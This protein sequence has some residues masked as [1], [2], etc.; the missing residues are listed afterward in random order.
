MKAIIIPTPGEIT[1]RNVSSPSRGENDV[2]VKVR[3]MGICGSDINA[4]RGT[5]PLV[6]YPRIIGHEIAGEVAEIPAGENFLAV[7]DRVVIE[8]YVYCGTCYP[9]MTQRTNCCENLRVRGVHIDGGMSEYCAHPRHLVHKVA[10][11]VSW[12]L[13]AMVEPLTISVHA[14]RR[15]RLEAGEHLVVTGA[16]PI[17]ILAALFAKILGAVPIVLDPLESRLE[18]ARSLGIENT[19]NL[20]KENAVERI[21]DLTHGRMAEALVEASGNESAVRSSIDYVSYASRISLVGWPKKEVS[22]PTAL[23]T[24]KEIDVMGSRNSFHAF[25][26]SISLISENKINI[27]PLISEVVPFEDIPR[28]LKEVASHPESFMKIV[29]VM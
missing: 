15:S 11:K 19:V 25:P 12:E 9:C 10:D 6:T 13:L 27:R 29:G 21:R 4:Y 20:N 1:L 7:G 3:S 23:F 22:L 5:N 16:G 18:F 28:I 17:G 8:P 2:L 24:K 14:V 26:E